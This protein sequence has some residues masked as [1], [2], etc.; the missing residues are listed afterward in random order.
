VAQARAFDDAKRDDHDGNARTRDEHRVLRPPDKHSIASYRKSPHVFLQL[1]WRQMPLPESEAL[2]AGVLASQRYQAASTER[3]QTHK[4]QARQKVETPHSQRQ[5]DSLERP[6]LVSARFP[7]NFKTYRQ[8]A[9]YISPF[10]DEVM[11]GWGAVRQC[12]NL[13][14]RGAPG[15]V[16]QSSVGMIKPSMHTS[17]IVLFSQGRFGVKYAP[18]TA[19]C[20]WAIPCRCTKGRGHRPRE[21]IMDVFVAKD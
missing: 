4:P 1:G 13:D 20:L 6:R 11:T 16:S 3:G 12:R 7:V 18:W 19:S 9:Q 10:N 8:V 14:M 2:V 15:G 5:R 21:T 17:A